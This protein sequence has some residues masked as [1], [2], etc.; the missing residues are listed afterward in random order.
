M[1]TA[2]FLNMAP[3]GYLTEQAQCLL[4]FNPIISFNFGK[5]WNAVR[6]TTGNIVSYFMHR[7][8]H[9]VLKGDDG[10]HFLESVVL[11]FQK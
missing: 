7:M 1:S 6:E 9:E 5:L 8:R 4:V 11:L 3:H 2:Y 10:E